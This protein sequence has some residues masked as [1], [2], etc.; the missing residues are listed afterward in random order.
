EGCSAPDRGDRQGAA[1]TLRLE[2]DRHRL[3]R[4]QRCPLEPTL[5]EPVETITQNGRPSRGGRFALAAPPS[6]LCL[7]GRNALLQRQGEVTRVYPGE[8]GHPVERAV[9]RD[10]RVDAV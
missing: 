2:A 10:D 4:G 8:P 1:R 9:G 6:D 7:T 5:V 3:R